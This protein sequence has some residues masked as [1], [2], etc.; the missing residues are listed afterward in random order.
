MCVCFARSPEPLAH[1]DVVD[2]LDELCRKNLIPPTT[3]P[4]PFAFHSYLR[5]AIY[6]DALEI[7][8]CTPW[9]SGIKTAKEARA[10]L[11]SLLNVQLPAAV[12]ATDTGSRGRVAPRRA[13][14]MESY[15]NL[16]RTAGY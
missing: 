5:K 16:V 11:G 4:L 9:D 8:T 15:E 10:K 2:G 6:E 13:D 14:E 1:P 7:L 12:N 3:P